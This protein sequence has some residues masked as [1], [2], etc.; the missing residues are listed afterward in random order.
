MVGRTRTSVYLGVYDTEEKAAKAYDLTALKYFG[1]S[2]AKLNFP[3]SDYEKQL[4]EMKD[5]TR[6]EFVCSIRRKSTCFSRGTSI[7]R[8]VTRHRRE[9]SKWQARIGRLTGTKELHLGSFDTEEEAAIAYDLAA[10]ELRGLKA[11]TNFDIS[12]YIKGNPQLTEEFNKLK[13]IAQAKNKQA[14]KA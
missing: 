6:D 10:V 5:M 1:P 8:G 13:E 11:V 12:N 4:E 14:N 2:A 7:Y 9:G 3:I